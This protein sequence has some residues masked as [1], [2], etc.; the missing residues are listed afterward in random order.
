MNQ[1]AGPIRRLVPDL[2]PAHV[3]AWMRLEAGDASRSTSLGPA[4]RNVAAP[5]DASRITTAAAR[6]G[7][8]HAGCCKEA[9]LVDRVRV[10]DQLRAAP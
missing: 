9:N 7:S 5:R 6:D 10:R 8:D 4:G 2:D 1:Y 3:E